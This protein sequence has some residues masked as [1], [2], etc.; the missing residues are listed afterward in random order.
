MRTDVVAKKF[1]ANHLK[2]LGSFVP[3]AVARAEL[4]KV[5]LRGGDLSDNAASHSHLCNARNMTSIE[6]DSFVR[7]EFTYLNDDVWNGEIRAP[8][9]KAEIVHSR[10]GPKVETREIGNSG[11]R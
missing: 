10:H 4:A 8:H 3:V 11:K 2:Q 6:R 9:S 7:D 1:A 5:V